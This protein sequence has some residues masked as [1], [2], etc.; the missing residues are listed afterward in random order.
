MSKYPNNNNN[1]NKP[2]CKTAFALYARGQKSNKW[3]EE[4]W[5]QFLKKLVGKLFPSTFYGSYE[6]GKKR[7]EIHFLMPID[8]DTSY[9]KVEWAISVQTLETALQP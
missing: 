4:K 3:F 9:N 5:F 1:N 6:A 8:S 7:P 2:N